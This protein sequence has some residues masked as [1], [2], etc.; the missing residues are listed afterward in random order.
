[1]NINPYIYFPVNMPERK[2]MLF[3]NQ[4]RKVSHIHAFDIA[5]NNNN[6]NNISTLF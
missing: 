2:E 1:M 4:L 5:N 6:N 3:A